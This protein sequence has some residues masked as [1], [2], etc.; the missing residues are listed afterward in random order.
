MQ[1]TYDLV[2]SLVTLMDTQKGILM[3]LMAFM[4]NM[5]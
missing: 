2:M 3:N 1:S 5:A 4:E